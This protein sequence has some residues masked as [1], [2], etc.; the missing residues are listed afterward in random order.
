MKV[1]R[2]LTVILNVIALTACNNVNIEGDWIEPI[3]G[4]ENMIQ[5]ISLKTDGKASS[6][7]MATLQY[8]KWEQK[9]NL[10]ILSGTSIGNHQTLSFTDTLK[11]EKLTKD[12]L[13]I[14][15]GELVLKYS[16]VNKEFTPM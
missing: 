2:N 16:K 10:L 12:S 7:N 11:I 14:R 13:I 5:G 6:I 8:E 4:M 3:P 1:F 9:D 15:K